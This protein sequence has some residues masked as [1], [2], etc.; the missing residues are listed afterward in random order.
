MSL[1]GL[2]RYPRLA[3][4]QWLPAET[5]R[6]RRWQRLQIMLAHAFANSPFYRRRF[7]DLGITPA[8]I[9][10]ADDFAR[11]P[12]TTREDLR[13][14]ENLIARGFGKARL[15]RSLSSGASGRRT[16]SYTRPSVRGH[17]GLDLARGAGGRRGDAVPRAATWGQTGERRVLTRRRARA[18]EL[19]ERRRT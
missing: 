19:A 18:S 13:E 10:S 2:M 4:E 15:K 12:V 11:I 5:I 9:R 17:D 3:R 16:S 8:D 6:R 14:A 7:R 1:Q